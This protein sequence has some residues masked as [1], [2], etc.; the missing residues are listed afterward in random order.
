MRDEAANWELEEQT[1]DFLEMPILKGAQ[2][3]DLR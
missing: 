3:L 2:T 1:L